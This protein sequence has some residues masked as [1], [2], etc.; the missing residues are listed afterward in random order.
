RLGNALYGIAKAATDKMT[1]DCAQELAPFDVACV[2][3]YPGMVRTESVVAA[4]KGGAF[5]LDGSESPE[6]QGRVI[7]ALFADPDRMTKTGQALVAAGLARDYGLTDIDGA[8]PPVLTL[9]T[10][11]G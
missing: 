6:F 2:S 7:A 8:T 11:P 1:A 9:E 5:S 3:L 4:A 10:L